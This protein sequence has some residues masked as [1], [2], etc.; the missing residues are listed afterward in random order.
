MLAKLTRRAL[1]VGLGASAAAAGGTTWS[2][3]SGHPAEGLLILTPVEFRVVQALSEVLF[4]GVHF[5][6]S[7]VE[8]GVAEEVDR[9]VAENLDPMHGN[10]FRYILR[11]LE[12]GTLASRGRQFSQLPR[13]IQLEVLET[14]TEP[15]VLP[16][17]IAGESIKAVLGMAYFAHPE[18]QAAMGWRTGCR[19]AA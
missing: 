10:G 15:D 2:L 1:L 12:W 11:A 4:P 19:G 14:W 6:L 18:V 5:P 16:R 17:R 3:S 8:A 9:M 13:G 7:G